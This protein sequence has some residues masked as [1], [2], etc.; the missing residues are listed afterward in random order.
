M[1]VVVVG[2]GR[3]GRA[4]TEASVAAELDCA[5]V[6]RTSGWDALEGPQGD[7]VV[8]AVRNDDLVE[9]VARIPPHRR[10][11]LVVI[12][13]GFLR[14]WLR[15]NSMERVTRGLLYFAVAK[16]GDPITPGTT[17]W[18]CGLHGLAMARWM[19]ALGVRAECVDWG[20]FSFYEIEKLCWLVANGLL[21]AKH[22]AP[23][24]VVATAHR[25]ELTALV[26]ELKAVGRAALGVDAPTT[27]LV[28]R[29]CAYSETLPGYRASMSEW[30]WRG[31]WFLEAGRRHSVPMPRF[32]GLIGAIGRMELLG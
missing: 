28:T 21:C 16:R 24:D 2:A 25:E 15:A 26:E 29:M 3:V 31:G 17:S 14:S 13:N 18:F 27:W 23:V 7:P 11:D 9:V 30:P 22:A 19:A 10:G 1:G 20:R 5:L 4:L 32:E 6:D 12:Q 8:L